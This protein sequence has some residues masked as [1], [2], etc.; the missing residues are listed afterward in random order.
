VRT[1]GGTILLGRRLFGKGGEAV[2]F[3]EGAQWLNTD[4]ALTLDELRG[5]IVLLDFWTYCCINCMHVI[6]DLRRLEEKYPE[7]VVVGVHSAKFEN[8]RD[9]SNI[10]AAI[11][12][13]GI[14]HPVLVDNGF[15]LW[16]AYGVRAWPSFVLIDPA[17]NVAGQASGEGAYDMFDAT[18]ASLSAAFGEQGLVRKDRM[19]FKL[20]K[21]TVP[22]DVLSFP[23]KVA[24][25][26]RG[27]RL[28]V[29]DSN[30]HRV[31]V[32]TPEGIVKDAIGSGAQGRADGAF[33]EASFLRQQGLAYDPVSDALFIADTENHL[34]RRAELRARTVTT[35]LGTGEQGGRASGGR[36][37]DVAISSPWDLVVLGEHLYIAMAGTHT[38]WRMPLTTQEAER[39]A[40]S[41][42]EDIIDGPRRQ[43]AL[44]QPSGIATDGQYIYFAD[45]EVSAVRAVEGDRVRTII[46]EGLFEFGD[47]DGQAPRARLQHPIGIAWRDGLLYVADTYNHKVKVVDP[48]TRTSKSL[49]GTGER[50]RDDGPA[51]SARLNEPNGLAF[52]GG[53]LYIADTN[54][55]ALRVYDPATGAVG[56][57]MVRMPAPA[58]RPSARSY[59]GPRARTVRLPPVRVSPR[60]RAVVLRLEPP[61]G[62][63]WN[64]EAPSSIAVEAAPG[65]P[66]RVGPPEVDLDAFE[67]RVPLEMTGAEGTATIRTRANVFFCQTDE[68]LCRMD[69]VELEL[70]LEVADDGQDAPAA[71]HRLAPPV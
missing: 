16:H 30:H 8:E 56:T 6:P 24:A 66:V 11:L 10:S 43:A 38:I 55:N 39:W 62:H 34:V 57:L 47:V 67:V 71:V 4:H 21:D 5:R 51:A 64:R 1:A 33:G 37:T 14:E 35:V 50:G 32:M 15:V 54:N 18:I 27:G 41:G 28:F 45:S 63:E 49:I 40:G 53:H 68:G 17:G 48:R 12:R 46:G 36:G 42:A 61:E 26:E 19:R 13:Y 23:G 65:G 44:A 60:A 20:L 29:S 52:L 9:A 25:D 69:S 22:E 31:L 59:P 3:P 70:P 7:L 2:E 58:P